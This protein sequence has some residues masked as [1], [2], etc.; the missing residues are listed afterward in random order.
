[1]LIKHLVIIGVGLIGGSLARR[2]R[3]E[4]VVQR[5]TGVGRGKA[6]L[7]KAV[8]LGVID[9]WTHSVSEAI[10]DADMVV[11]CVPMGAYA[12]VFQGMANTLAEHAVVTDA[13]STK[14]YA[15]DLAEKHLPKSAQFVAGHPI[16]GTEHSGVEASFS[17]LY[18][19][20]YCLITPT[21]SNSDKAVSAVKDMWKHTGA[22]VICMPPDEH[23]LLL[24]SVSHLPH[25]AAYAL[26]NAV[27][28]SALDAKQPFQFAAGGFRDFTR[29]A[30]SS[31][32]MW[33]D[34]AQSNQAA[35]LQKMDALIAEMQ[36]MRQ[37]IADGNV[38]ALYDDFTQAKQARDLWLAEHGEK[39]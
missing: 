28:K 8:E 17:S 10:S 32:Q 13:G 35:L 26:V 11:I 7:E 33:C 12:T 5:I 27:R 6:N 25:L 18:Q 24:A 30:S 39:H 2:L 16:A 29:I 4:K 31:P 9:A 14:Q 34:I 37:N 36:A 15:I 19:D 38:Q 22:K 23:D 21:S 20:H 1:M 3:Q